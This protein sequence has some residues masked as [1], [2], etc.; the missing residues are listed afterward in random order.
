M[1][2]NIFCTCL[3]I[4]IVACSAPKRGCDSFKSCAE[5]T[6]FHKKKSSRAKLE[7]LRNLNRTC[8]QDTIMGVV[9]ESLIEI[10]LG[11]SSFSNQYL[12]D[13]DKPG[14]CIGPCPFR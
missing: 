14:L 4:F 1:N 10:D 13:N 12:L 5:S 8:K 7:A 11:E 6:F 3:A 9:L 2:R